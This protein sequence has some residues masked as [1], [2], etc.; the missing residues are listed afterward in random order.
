[1][2]N[3]KISIFLN[4]PMELKQN[5]FNISKKYNISNKKLCNL[6]INNHL[7][8][9]ENDKI[10]YKIYFATRFNNFTSF[11]FVTDDLIR[12]K[13]KELAF[14]NNVRYCDV[15]ISII[16]N[17]ICKDSSSDYI[18]YLINN[19]LNLKLGEFKKNA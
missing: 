10:V 8:N 18:Y 1:M 4:L 9:Y 12:K 17:Y 16:D 15:I 5:L 3:K 14:K 7:E 6:I 2:K 19:K 11:C 13:I